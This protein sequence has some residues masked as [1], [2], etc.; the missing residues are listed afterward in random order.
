M[1]KRRVHAKAPLTGLEKTPTG[2][3]GLDEITSGGLPKGR[4]TLVC[5]S[6]GC[7][8]SLLAMEFLV[9][10]ATQYK[11]PGLFI[12]FEETE[13]ELAQNLASLGFDLR[14]LCAAKKLKIDHIRLERS[15]IEETGEYDLEGLFILLGEAIDSIGARRVVLDTIEVLFAGLSNHAIVRSELRRL[16]GWLKAKGVTA[17]ITGERGHDSMTRYGLEEYV[18]DCVIMLDHRV[19]DQ[20]STRRIR[21]VKY[22]GSQHGT[23]EF[24]FLITNTGIS[25]L[26]IT[27]L[28][29]DYPVTTRRIASGVAQ[30]DTLL[31]GEGYYRGSSVLISGSAGTGKTTLATAFAQAAC[32]RGERC[33][34]I[35]LEESSAQI[36]RNM[37]SVGIHLEAFAEQGLLR[38]HTTRPGTQGLEAHLAT[39]HDLV[40]G[41][42]PAAIVLDPVTN[43]TAVGPLPDVK[44]MLAR[45]IDFVKMEHITLLAT[46][47]TSGGDNEQ[48]SEVGISSLMDSWILLR[49]LESNGE[50]N[51]GLYILKSRGMAHS[52]QVREFILSKK[53][54]QLVEV[55]TG[56]G[57]VLTGSARVAQI[58]RDR[59]DEIRRQREVEVN[60]L[61]IER[62]RAVAASRVAA[63]EAEIEAA[64]AELAR[65]EAADIAAGQAAALA[66]AAISRS[67][68]VD[69]APAVHGGRN[70]H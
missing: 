58:E 27:S 52:N 60:R 31:G 53:G 9:R 16:F 46:S 21:I 64:D 11:E 55:Y 57:N 66:R 50:R 10:G 40:T 34:Y 49:N 7:G 59:A 56:S 33:L 18:A 39:I 38:F 8:K 51:R 4:P 19:A 63:L 25:V 68:M 24:P 43:L 5:G 44:S 35:A 3:R 70:G 1:A 45:V 15:E 29:L 30:L 36:I 65:L 2:I 6:A 26:P 54:I 67:R 13:E 37:R 61:A 28:G 42:K 69:A 12:A 22:R 47:L 14:R 23:N 62:R 17:I 20:V 32:Q 48:Q 41:F